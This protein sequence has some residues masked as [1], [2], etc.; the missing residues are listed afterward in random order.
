[1]YKFELFSYPDTTCGALRPH[2]VRMHY[3]DGF[4]GDVHRASSDKM[5]LLPLRGLL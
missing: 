2:R 5:F 1:M 3:A 4:I